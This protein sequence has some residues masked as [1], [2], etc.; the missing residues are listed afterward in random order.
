[1]SD[2]F[3]RLFSEKNSDM[4]ITLY[5]GWHFFYLA[6]IFGTALT[7][8]LV[9]RNKSHRAKRIVTAV[10][11]SLTLILYIGDFFIM[12]LSDSY[13][14]Q[15]STYKLPF[16]IC[17]LMALFAPLAQF[18]RHLKKYIR[19]AVAMLSLASTMMWMVYPGSALGGQP[20]FCY[21][22]FQTFMY[23]G[24][25]FIWGC[26]TIALGET[27]ISIKKCWQDLIGILIIFVWAWLGNH[28]YPDNWN[29]FFIEESIF[30][31]LPDAV[32][33]VAVIFGVFSVC[34]C[35]YGIYY[36]ICGICR[37]ATRKKQGG[38]PACNT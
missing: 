18:D 20:P 25:L 29:W 16:N 8:S 12:P 2:F 6:L 37:L 28:I 17:T 27:K 10:F 3:I 33:P 30:P 34:L 32:M 1:M 38:T 13:G 15:I 35:I 36:A 5:S 26:L 7:L 31:F 19:P 9:F 4:S 14:F 23:H 22:I 21:L 11:A 24:V